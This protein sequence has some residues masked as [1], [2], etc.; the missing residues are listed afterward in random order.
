MRIVFYGLCELTVMTAQ[1]FIEQNHDIIIMD[2]NKEKI[3]EIKDSMDCNFLVG[4]AIHPDILKETNPKEVDL[5]LALS[6]MSQNNLVA[7][8]VGRSLGAKRVILRVDDPEYRKVCAELG[9]LDVIVS[10]QIVSEYLTDVILNENI[11]KL[12]RNVRDKACLYHIPIHEDKIEKLADLKLP[13]KT[14]VIYYLRD[15]E[16]HHYDDSVSFQKGDEII[17]LTD[18]DNLEKLK[19][20]WGKE[21]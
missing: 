16:F 11:L 13:Q 21:K 20:S 12:T 8:L 15:G 19:K 6:D 3:E 14:R 1:K 9:L 10:P 5:F 7:C 4:D 17:L 2:P 18:R